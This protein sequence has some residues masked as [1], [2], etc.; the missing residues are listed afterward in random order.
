MN[1]PERI[2]RRAAVVGAG[3]AGLTAAWRLRQ[4]GFDVAVYEREARA[5]GRVKSV[6]VGDCTIDTGATVFLA[7]YR[8]ALALIREMGLE[9][10]LEPVRGKIVVPRDGRLH[11]ID[12][13][14]PL[15]AAMT[16]VVG[17]RSKLALLKL[18]AR[19]WKLR[20][21]LNFETLGSARGQDGETLADFAHRLPPE[22]YEYLLNPALKFLYLHDGAAGSVIELLWWMHATGA[23]KPRSLKRGTRSLIDA[24]VDRLHVQTNVE[25]RA[26][27]RTGEGVQLD[28]RRS[29]G[30]DEQVSADACVVAVPAPIAERI[31]VDGLTSFQREFLT[32]RRYDPSIQVS[33]CTRRRP[34]REAL[35]FLIPD[36]LNADV[37]T[38]IFGHHIGRER[39]PPERGIVNAYLL[40]SWSE[41]HAQVSDE[42]T[43]RAA[44]AVVRALVPEVDDCVGWNVQRWPHTAAVT[45]PGDCERMHRFEQEADPRSPIQL[46]GDY[47]V[48]AS[49]NVAVAGGNRV[50]QRLAAAC[51]SIRHD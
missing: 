4:A 51:P 32:S 18:A 3:L 2:V 48:Q 46:I 33:F 43:M 21:L 1:A 5:S 44:Q 35:M 25:V 13:D 26:V 38:V 11:E 22:L 42:D 30:M 16:G 24:L 29:G 17:W 28:L 19:F 34:A 50:A 6:R 14:A 31:C 20:P 41:R 47:Q 39:A 37:A 23:G 45:A 15:S 40:K 36:S 12:P 8:E 27:R 10:E 7:A 9:N 49:M